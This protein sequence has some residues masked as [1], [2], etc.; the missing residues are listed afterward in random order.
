MPAQPN[1]IA[2]RR[3]RCVFMRINSA[4]RHRASAAIDGPREARSP[5]TFVTARLVFGIADVR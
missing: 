1:A 5:R 3:D 2:D 4:S